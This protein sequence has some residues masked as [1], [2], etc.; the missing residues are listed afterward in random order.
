MKNIKLFVYALIICLSFVSVAEA[1]SRSGSYKSGFSSQKR[2]TAKPA[3]T[4]YKPPAATTET[5]KTAFGSFGATNS[6]TQ[7]NAAAAPQSQ[8]SKDL[9]TTAAQS[10]AL[11]TADARSK[12]NEKTIATNS[13]SGWFRSG[14]QTTAAQKPNNATVNGPAPQ[15]VNYQPAAQ[16]YS[17]NQSNGLLHGLMGFMIGHSLAQQHSNTVY[18]PQQNQDGQQGISQDANQPNNSTDANGAAA[19]QQVQDVHADETESFFMK[20][21][22]VLLWVAMLSGIIFGVRKVMSLRHRKL[23]RVTNYSLGS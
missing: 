8:M 18:V 12:G 17:G 22:R 4:Y 16:H 13:D 5:K 7:Q 11:K 21:V 2:T 19:P 9:N 6:K 20:L 1:K 10:N 23:T 14:S 3:S 15:P